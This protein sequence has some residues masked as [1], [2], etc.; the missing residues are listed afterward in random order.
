MKQIRHEQY[1]IGEF[2]R[3]LK[4]GEFRM[5]LQPQVEKDGKIIG[6]EALSRWITADGTVV[7]PGEFIGILERS[8]LIVRLDRYIW[9]EA[10]KKLAAWKNTSFDSLYISINISPKDFYYLDV[11][12]YLEEL[13]ERYQVPRSRL[14]LEITESVVMQDAIKQLALVNRLHEQGYDIEIDDFG[15]GYSSLS[16]LKD[17]SAD[18]IKIDKEFL[19][20]S[21]NDLKSERILVSVFDLSERLNMRVITEGVETESQL[22]K[23]IRLGC[24]MFQ[25]FYFARPMSVDWFEELYL[26]SDG[27]IAG[28][29]VTDTSVSD[30]V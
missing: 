6:C 25:G 13:I 18:T 15:K 26:E 28:S 3:A 1:V 14:K 23:L 17:I 29:D 5:F 10:V 4:D 22:Q 20:E 7:P 21:D 27:M 12:T 2:E 24:H 30:P 11:F 19:R 16:L 8:E 9:E